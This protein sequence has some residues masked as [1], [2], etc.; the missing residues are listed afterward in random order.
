M[1]K[2]LSKSSDAGAGL[3]RSPVRRVCFLCGARVR[4]QNPSPKINTC[5]PECTRAKK[6]GRTREEQLKYEMELDAVY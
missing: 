4:N 1:N 2:A 3:G 5:S 6:A